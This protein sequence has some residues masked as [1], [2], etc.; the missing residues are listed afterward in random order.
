[1]DWFL[2]DRTS[3]KKELMFIGFVFSKIQ[4]IKNYLFAEFFS[5]ICKV[6]LTGQTEELSI[7]LTDTKY[8]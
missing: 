1:M 7:F 3:L 4:K 8:M 5:G 6:K 2:Y